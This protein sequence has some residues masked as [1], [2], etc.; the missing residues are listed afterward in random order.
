MDDLEF[1]SYGALGRG[2]ADEV[3]AARESGGG[4]GCRIGKLAGN[5]T[6]THDVVNRDCGVVGFGFV[7]SDGHFAVGWVGEEREQGGI[8]RLSRGDG[9]SVV[10]VRQSD[11]RERGGAVGGVVETEVETEVKDI[12]DCIG[13]AGKDCMG[14][15]VAVVE[16]D[17]ARRESVARSVNGVRIR[18]RG[19]NSRGIEDGHIEVAVALPFHADGMFGSIMGF[20]RDGS[21]VGIAESEIDDA[22]GRFLDVAQ[23]SVVRHARPRAEPRF[24]VVGERVD[25][26]RAREGRVGADVAI[27]GWRRAGAYGI[28]IGGE[29]V[30]LLGVASVGDIAAR[31]IGVDVINQES[32]ARDILVKTFPL[33]VFEEEIIARSRGV[34]PIDLESSDRGIY[35][36]LSRVGEFDGRSP[37]VDIGDGVGAMTGWGATVV[38]P[39][40]RGHNVVGAKTTIFATRLAV[41]GVVIVGS[42][43]D[44]AQLVADHADIGQ[45]SASTSTAFGRAGIRSES[46]SVIGRGVPHVPLMAPDAV[47]ASASLFTIAGKENMYTINDTITVIVVAR[48]VGHAFGLGDHLRG[49]HILALVGAAIIAH[50]AVACNRSNHIDSEVKLVVGS[51]VIEVTDT[52]VGPIFVVAL[53]VEEHIDIA[54]AVGKRAILSLEENHESTAFADHRSLLGGRH[55]GVRE[56]FP[57]G[58]IRVNLSAREAEMTRSIGKKRKDLS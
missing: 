2:E 35:S 5:Q 48:E 46:N 44:V 51:L 13:V 50:L 23:G 28:G 6:T 52:A 10:F 20:E 38:V 7:K 57:N 25:M 53:L 4:D 34:Y 36:H 15:G 54:F 22:V 39:G 45:L 26:A 42:A 19:V 55:V 58:E 49:E 27:G 41:V 47:G 30:E 17:I 14:L 3:G 37:M 18:E 8:G 31:S 43:E 24:G 21:D 29:D 32:V 1:A 40:A 11:G 9:E 12:R 56:V 33:T 16:D